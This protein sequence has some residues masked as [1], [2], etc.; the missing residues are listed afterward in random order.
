ELARTQ[1]SFLLRAERNELVCQPVWTARGPARDLK[2]DGDAGSVV[3]ST[4]NRGV[5]RIVMGGDDHRVGGRSLQP[6]DDVPRIDRA[7]SFAVRYEGD[8]LHGHG[9]TRRFHL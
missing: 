3:I 1:E 5:P 8:V 4:G 7:L 2:Q 9:Q 6:A